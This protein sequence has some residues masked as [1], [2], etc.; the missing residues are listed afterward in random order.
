MTTLQTSRVNVTASNVDVIV[1]ITL[2]GPENIRQWSWVIHGWLILVWFVPSE[3]LCRKCIWS[4][5]TIR[6]K[7]VGAGVWGWRPAPVARAAWNLSYRVQSFAKVC[8]KLQDSFITFVR[9]P[10]HSN[11]S[12]WNKKSVTVMDFE[13]CWCWVTLDLLLVA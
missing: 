2:P 10:Y 6:P 4:D 7:V 3:L 8:H 5:R 9:L 1:L 13:A 12:E 11:G